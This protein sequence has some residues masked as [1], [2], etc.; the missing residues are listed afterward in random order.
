MRLFLAVFSC[1]AYNYKADNI[2]DWFTRPV[3]DRLAGVRD[4]W[5]K[6]VN[7]DYKIFKGFSNAK[8]ATDEI[9]LNCKDDYYHSADK[10]RGV[11]DYTLEHEYDQLVKI[12]DDVW[13]YWDRLMKAAPIADYVGAGQ[14]NSQYCAGFTYWL[15]RHAMETLQACPQGSWAEDRWVGESLY[16]RGIRCSV[17]NRYYIAPFTR[18]CQ[19][20]S[21]AELERPND[22]LTIHS[23]TPLQ[24]RRLHA[25]RGS[26]GRTRRVDGVL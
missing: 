9:F 10:I 22:H 25:G 5:L 15:S 6:D 24:M 8:P 17:D 3:V 23:L 20:I 21:D 12:D 1:H 14:K 2:N 16:R 13:V 26:P 11:I 7:C 4:S 18:T 19:F